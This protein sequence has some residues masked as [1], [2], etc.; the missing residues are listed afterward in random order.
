MATW[1]AH[2]DLIHDDSYPEPGPEHIMKLVESL[3]HDVITG[4]KGDTQIVGPREFGVS[5]DVGGDTEAE[6]EVEARSAIKIDSER[7]PGW[8]IKRIRILENPG[9]APSG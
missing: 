3:P 7:F 6:A 1:L 8:A 9:T 5:F 4:S 2:V